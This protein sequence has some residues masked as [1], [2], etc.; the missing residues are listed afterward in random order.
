M[1]NENERFISPYNIK[2]KFDIS[3]NTLRTWAEED[4]VRYVRI[5]DGKGKRLYHE[6]DIERIFGGKVSR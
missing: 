4:K 1:N 5:R 3:S 6:K 2:K